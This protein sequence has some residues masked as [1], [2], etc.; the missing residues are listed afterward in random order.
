MISCNRI[1]IVMSAKLL[2]LQ[3]LLPVLEI[4]TRSK[5]PELAAEAAEEHAQKS[6]ELAKLRRNLVIHSTGDAHREVAMQG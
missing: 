2:F 3:T 1:E 4:M 5:D 6:K